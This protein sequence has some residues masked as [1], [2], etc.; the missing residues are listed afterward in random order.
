MPYACLY[1]SIFSRLDEVTKCLLYIYL[2]CH[3]MLAQ[4]QLLLN[5][6][7][8]TYTTKMID[9]TETKCMMT[10]ELETL[11]MWH[12]LAGV[13]REIALTSDARSVPR[14]PLLFQKQQ[15]AQH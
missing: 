1:A 11:G 10:W 4:L 3:T 2:N 5:I 15:D 9:V 8:S 6:L 13:R 14:L 7:E 12:M